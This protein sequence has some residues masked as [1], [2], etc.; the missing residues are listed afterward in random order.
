MSTALDVARYLLAEH[1]VSGRTQVQ[2]LL[3]YAQGLALA[4]TGEPLFSEPIEARAQ[5]PVVASVWSAGFIDLLPD[6]GEGL[7]PAQRTLV[8][9]AVSRYGGL[10]EASL[11]AA[12][13]A[14]N[15]W[16][17]AHVD[18]SRAG[19]ITLASLAAQFTNVTDTRQ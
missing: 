15:P 9:E 4:R 6:G 17:G 10:D 7:T 14:E 11:A 19:I 2:G 13:R 5:G 12:I 3:Y 1:P 18:P 8:D 16:R